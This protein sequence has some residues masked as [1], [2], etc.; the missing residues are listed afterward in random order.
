MSTKKIAYATS[1]STDTKNYYLLWI[2]GGAEPD[3][4]ACHPKSKN[5]I[6]AENISE[7]NSI[8]KEIDLE[9]SDDEVANINISELLR[10]LKTI[11]GRP[12]STKTATCLLEGWNCLEDVARLA[13]IN[14]QD[15]SGGKD[16]SGIYEKLFYGNN[17]PAVTPSKSIYHPVFSK[18]ERRSIRHYLLNLWSVVAETLEELKSSDHQPFKFQ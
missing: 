17:L 10:H 8:A 14:F 5:I 16:L 2:N 3:S 4:F 12:F 9:L 7:L 15:L 1:I 13:Q 11:D 6:V 18:S